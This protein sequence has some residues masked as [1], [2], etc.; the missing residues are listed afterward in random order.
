MGSRREDWIKQIFIKDKRGKIIVQTSA[1]GIV[2][3]VHVEVPDTMT[4]REID[5]MTRR[6]MERVNQKHSVLRAS[7]G[8][9]SVNTGNDESGKMYERIQSIVVP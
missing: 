2:G 7:I 8:I 9:Y 5:A 3:S 1:I 6:I 4:A